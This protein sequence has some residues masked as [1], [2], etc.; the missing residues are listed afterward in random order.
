MNRLI[1]I[2]LAAI[3]ATV[4]FAQSGSEEKPAGTWNL[5]VR[6]S[7]F[8]N[9]E[10]RTYLSFDFGLGVQPR[11]DVGLRGTFASVGFGNTI[12]PIRSGGSDFELFVRHRVV[13]FDGLSLMGG[14]SFPNTPAQNQPFA[15]FRADYAL[16]KPEFGP[17][18]TIG[19]RGV[20]RQD[21]SIVGIS[22]GLNFG[23]AD[24]WELFGDITGIVHGDNTRDTRT[25][26]ALRRALW[27]AGVKYNLRSTG[28]AGYDGSIYLA[29]TN[30]LGLTT[31]TS[32][33][34]S[35]GDRP[36]LTIGFSLRGRS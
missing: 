28:A 16:K 11:W 8:R 26:Q 27:G 13:Q 20:L 1:G 36:A 14:V 25:G 24:N 34:T 33:S 4:A 15:T 21:S 5:D 19:A 3:S 22:A 7:F 30:A 31:G 12:A 23:F 2:A 9:T 18:F 29:V 10:D 17:A 6:G 32:L 35:L